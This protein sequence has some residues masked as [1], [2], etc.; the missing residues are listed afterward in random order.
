MTLIWIMADL[1]TTNDQTEVFQLTRDIHGPQKMNLR[2]ASITLLFVNDI[3]IP[4]LAK[5]SPHS[6]DA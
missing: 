2:H 3:L 1:S 4:S 5:L 6:W